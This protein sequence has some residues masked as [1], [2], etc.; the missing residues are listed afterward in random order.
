MVLS[1]TNAACLHPSVISLLLSDIAMSRLCI[2]L[3]FNCIPTQSYIQSKTPTQTKHR[4]SQSSL[5]GATTLFLHYGPN[6]T[7]NCP[8]QLLQPPL[9]SVR[10]QACRHSMF[11]QCPAALNRNTPHKVSAANCKACDEPLAQ[12][13]CCRFHGFAVT[14]PCGCICNSQQHGLQ[15]GTRDLQPP[16]GGPGNVSD[17]VME[18]QAL[19]ARVASGAN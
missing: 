19:C 9:Q 18:Q 4:L 11:L 2:Q 16:R 8:C 13:S 6:K 1:L 5:T 7:D 12:Q 10:G 17:A 14:T 15:H 3:H